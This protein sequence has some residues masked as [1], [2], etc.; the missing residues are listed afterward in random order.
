MAVLGMQQFGILLSYLCPNIISV[1]SRSKIHASLKSY[2]AVIWEPYEML[3]NEHAINKSWDLT[4]DSLALWLADKLSIKDV[5]LIKSDPKVIE[6]SDLT[7]LSKMGVLDPC[8]I[9]WANKT[10]VNAHILHKSQFDK[11]T[12]ITM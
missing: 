5:L 3:K 1:D 7:E 9:E 11:F 8:F 12:Y 2:N 6:Q 4:S 10:N